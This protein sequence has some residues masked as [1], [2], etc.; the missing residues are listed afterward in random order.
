[1]VHELAGLAIDEPAFVDLEEVLSTNNHGEIALVKS[2]LEAEN[3]PYVAQGENFTM[4]APIPV[5]F[6][7][8]RE[9]LVRAREVLE[10]LL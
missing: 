6:L 10:D 1:M 7:V 8:P 2:L 5:R 4:R 3:I 9:H